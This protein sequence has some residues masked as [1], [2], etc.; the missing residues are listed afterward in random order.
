MIN[1]KQTRK[2]FALTGKKTNFGKGAENRNFTQMCFESDSKSVWNDRKTF[3]D[4]HIN[5][6]KMLMNLQHTNKL[7]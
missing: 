3:M 6:S 4:N 7:N 2:I 1:I 5:E